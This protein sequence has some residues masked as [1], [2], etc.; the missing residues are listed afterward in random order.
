MGMFVSI[1]FEINP[2]HFDVFVLLCRQN[3]T[4]TKSRTHIKELA[5]SNDQIGETLCLVWASDSLFSEG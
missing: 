5:L 3:L 2:F 1:H 4:E